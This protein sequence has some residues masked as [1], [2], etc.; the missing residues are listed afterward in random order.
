MGKRGPAPK[1]TALKV[2]QGNPGKRPLNKAE[3]KP[4]VGVG[5]PPQFLDEC[6]VEFWHTHAPVLEK[7]GVLT[8]AD[9][10]A[11]TL[12]CQAW[13]EW[14]K[15]HDEMQE[16]PAIFVAKSGYTQ[17]SGYVSLERQ[18]KADFKQLAA[19][20]GLT[21]SDRSGVQV[22]DNVKPVN[23]PLGLME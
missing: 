9:A 22:V 2:L 4:A 1:P 10:P 23:D 12:L 16:K 5:Q 18:R 15:A 6:A 8:V 21:P 11:W 19:K 14:R 3:P 7:L 13:S 17:V 20:F